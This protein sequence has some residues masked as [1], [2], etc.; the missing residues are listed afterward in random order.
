MQGRKTQTIQSEILGKYTQIL[1]TISK[2]IIFV[3]L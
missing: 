3:S 1:G 2:L